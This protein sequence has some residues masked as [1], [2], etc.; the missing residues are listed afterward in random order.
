MKSSDNR[1]GANVIWAK[2]QV[3]KKT[4]DQSLLDSMRS[5]FTV[6]LDD[7]VVDVYAPDFWS[8]R[9]MYEL[10]LDDKLPQDLKDNAKK[11]CDKGI[12]EFPRTL[13]EPGDATVRLSADVKIAKYEEIDLNS[14]NFG[15]TS[16]AYIEYSKRQQMADQLLKYSSYI[17]E[18]V[19][20]YEWEKVDNYHTIAKAF[21]NQVLNLY[22]QLAGN[23]KLVPY[24]C[25]MGVGFMDLYN[26]TKEDKYLKFAEKLIGA[27]KYHDISLF[28]KVT[29]AYF[30][31]KMR[32]LLKRDDYGPIYDNLF[33]D[34]YQNHYDQQ[35][36][37]LYE[38]MHPGK[39]FK[40]ENNSL[41]GIIL[42][43]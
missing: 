41:L 36:K 5:D 43:I 17:S 29:C 15:E 14:V 18:F 25:V 42:K 39:L 20:K 37:A 7:K 34:I 27:N 13:R 26:A 23:N 35:Y 21:Q 9:I 30:I 22:Q 40:A 2:Y 24:E 16:G 19:T 4:N 11:L 33:S 6:Q 8:C 32:T 3:W 28:D 10:W 1:V 38:D 12:Y 31:D